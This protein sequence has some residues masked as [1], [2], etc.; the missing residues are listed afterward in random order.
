MSQRTKPIQNKRRRG[1]TFLWIVGLALLVGLLIYL[2]QTALLY[3]VSTLGVTILL[4]IVAV[5]DLGD[6]EVS[7]TE[8]DQPVTAGAKSAK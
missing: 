2:E 8:I 4:V 6:R 3:V 1:I 7:S 5:A